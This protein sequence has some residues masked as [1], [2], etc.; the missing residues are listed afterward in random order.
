MM[1]EAGMNNG[2]SDMPRQNKVSIR[3][4]IPR[5]DYKELK[6]IARMERSDVSTLVRRAVAHHFFIPADGNTV[7]HQQ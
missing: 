3:V 1:Q 7:K 2:K 5:S 6:K 4:L